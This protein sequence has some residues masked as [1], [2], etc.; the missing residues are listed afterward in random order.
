MRQQSLIN[1][2]PDSSRQDIFVHWN[3]GIEIWMIWIRQNHNNQN[4][5]PDTNLPVSEVLWKVSIMWL[6]IRGELSKCILM[7]LFFSSMLDCLPPIVSANSPNANLLNLLCM[8]HIH[9]VRVDQSQLCVVQF[10]NQLPALQFP[11]SFIFFCNTYISP[12]ADVVHYIIPPSRQIHNRS[13]ICPFFP[14][15]FFLPTCWRPAS[16]VQLS[17]PPRLF[18]SIRVSE[19]RNE[20]AA[21]YAICLRG[22]KGNGKSIHLEVMI[23]NHCRN[24]R[25]D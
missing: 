12:L 2:F 20:L 4:S 21:K 6:L 7:S 17:I 25:R 22:M 19:R 8:D 1:S 18:P 15:S 24:G 13:V 16:F 9:R 23:C 11:S 3:G 5:Q 10:H 14:S